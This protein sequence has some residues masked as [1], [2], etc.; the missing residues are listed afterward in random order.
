MIRIKMADFEEKAELKE[1]INTF[2]VERDEYEVQTSE[3]YM[4][5]NNHKNKDL[6]SETI[7]IS[8]FDPKYEDSITEKEG[9]KMDMRKLK[10]TK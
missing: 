8:K 5:V 4:K 9:M 1:G 2:N 6:A 10:H 7:F 3:I